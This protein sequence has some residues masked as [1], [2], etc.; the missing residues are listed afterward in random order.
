MVNLL[1][2]RNRALAGRFGKNDDPVGCGSTCVVN[3][4]RKRHWSMAW[5]LIL[6]PDGLPGIDRR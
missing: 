1:S 2:L 4:R 5:I 3:G 6:R